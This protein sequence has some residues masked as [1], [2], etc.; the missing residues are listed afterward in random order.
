MYFSQDVQMFDPAQC[1]DF[2]YLINLGVG[3]FSASVGGTVGLEPAHKTLE[4]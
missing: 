2:P 3:H 1:E 4:A